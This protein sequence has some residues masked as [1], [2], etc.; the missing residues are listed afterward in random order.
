MN[1]NYSSQHI[2]MAFK[3]DRRYKVKQPDGYGIN[4]GDCG[5]TVEIFIVMQQ[6]QISD[7]YYLTDGC[8]DTNACANTVAHMASGGLIADAWRITS[9]R[10]VNYLK[11]LDP[12]HHHCAELAVGALY[13]ALADARNNLN[14]PW[15]RLYRP[16]Y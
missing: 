1:E 9:E 2:E 15:I 4:T 8:M 11:T 16:V 12:H 13:R 3:T 14:K 7:V 6:G 5:D 10:I